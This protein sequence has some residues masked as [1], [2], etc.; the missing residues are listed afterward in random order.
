MTSF[1]LSRPWMLVL[2]VFPI[3]FIVLKLRKY[4]SSQHMMNSEIFNHFNNEN[5]KTITK[6][7][8]YF[9]IPW[10]IGVIALS[11]PTLE[12]RDKPLYQNEEV[13]VWAMDLSNSMLADDIKP[14]RYMQMR[15]ALLQLLSKT[16]PEKKIAIVVF[17]GNAYTLLPPTN[18]FNTIKSYIRQLEPSQMPMQGSNPFRAVQLAEKIIND[19]GKLGNVL[20]ITDDLPHK[21]EA[22]VMAKFINDSKNRYFLYVIGTETGAALKQKDGTLIKDHEGH[23]VIAKTGFRN[24]EEL[25]KN[26][27]INIFHHDNEYKLPTIYSHALKTDPILIKDTYEQFDFGYLMAIPLLFLATVFRK[28]FIFTLLLGAFTLLPSFTGGST[29]YATDQEGIALFNDGQFFSAARAFENN[30]WKGNAYY[31]AG[32]YLSAIIF[33][34]KS[35]ESNTPLVIYNLANCYAMLGDLDTAI[36]LYEKVTATDNPHN[37]DATYNLNLLKQLQ[38]EELTKQ[39]AISAENVNLISTA[40]GG[41]NECS[42]EEGCKDLNPQDLIRNRLRNMQNRSSLKKGPLKQW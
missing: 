6:H 23:V 22:S 12:N 16:S 26:S 33:Y 34:E 40:D 11:G 15:Y 7:F 8:K 32:D 38:F 36:M 20:L 19:Y 1:F 9:A 24:I 5:T 21:E 42:K 29:A 2:L 18:D 28:G 27:K 39:H 30:R 37:Y 31:R 35:S 25:A 10:I 14:S 4:N 3:L 17:A 41:N 13:W